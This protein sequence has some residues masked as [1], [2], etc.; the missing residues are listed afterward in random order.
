MLRLEQT[1]QKTNITSPLVLRPVDGGQIDTLLYH[2]PQRANDRQS[3]IWPTNKPE[4]TSS[5]GA[6]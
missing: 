6:C 1:P 4:L 5:L 2:L 3:T